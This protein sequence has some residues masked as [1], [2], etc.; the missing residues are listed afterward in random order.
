MSIH[1]VGI[2]ALVLVFV[3]G[4]VRPVNLGALA[5]I[6]TYLVGTFLAGE[7]S[8]Q[9]LAGFPADLFVLLAGVTYLFGIASSNGT[10]EWVINHAVRHLGDR[11]AAIPWLI[12]GVAAIPS[13][14]G[15]LG[16][17]AVAMLAPLCLTLG[18][19]YGLDRRMSALMVMHGSAAG[20]FSPLNGLAI[21]VTNAVETN[22]LHITALGL[23]FGNAAYNLGL[24]V[25]IFLLFGGPELLARRKAIRPSRFAS[26]PQA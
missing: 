3:L 14:A 16:P 12:F 2:T 4:T 5:L 8:R 23:F 15:A 11:S 13:S 24:A 9:L 7:S 25:V 6:A 26:R 19:R 1:L 21:I 17:A 10:I 20:N 18:E 22:G